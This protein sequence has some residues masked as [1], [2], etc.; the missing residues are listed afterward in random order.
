M[1][2][3]LSLTLALLL[4]AGSLGLADA[5]GHKGSHRYGGTNRYG[6]GSHYYGGIGPYGRKPREHHPRQLKSCTE[7]HPCIKHRV[8]AP[9]VIAPAFVTLD[10]TPTPDATPVAPP[11]FVTPVAPIPQPALDDAWTILLRTL[12]IAI[13]AMVAILLLRA[14]ATLA[15]YIASIPMRLLR[16]RNA[17]AK[18]IASIPTRLLRALAALAKYIASIPIRWIAG[19]MRARS[20]RSRTR[21]N[22]AR[23][24]RRPLAGRDRAVGGTSLVAAVLHD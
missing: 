11:A 16:A 21:R 12:T 20:L 2:N 3:F 22:P 9:V 4:V 1:R 7:R 24:G 5:H 8:V 14:F 13:F 6:K 18:Y 17:V 23:P 19:R 15:K 10:A